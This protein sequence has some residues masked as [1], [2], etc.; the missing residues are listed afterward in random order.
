[1]LLIN[2]ISKEKVGNA[3]KVLSFSLVN[4]LS[5]AVIAMQRVTMRSNFLSPFLPKQQASNLALISTSLLMFLVQV[6]LKAR[7]AEG[8]NAL[9]VYFNCNKTLKRLLNYILT[10]L[11]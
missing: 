3:W 7:I 4:F 1:M 11:V 8:L 10:T 9:V 5:V 6:T 2:Q